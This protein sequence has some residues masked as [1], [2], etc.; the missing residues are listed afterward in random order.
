MDRKETGETPNQLLA[1]ILNTLDGI[2]KI[3]DVVSIFT[4]NKIKMFDDA[5]LRPGRI[6]KVITY[7]L[8]TKDDMLNFFK[9]Y[10]PEEETHFNDML[11][12]IDTISGDV[13]FATLKGICD[14]INIW[15]FNE[16]DITFEIIEEIIKDKIRR[17]DS[18]GDKDKFIL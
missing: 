8:P 13:P 4:T 17:K 6:D 7:R 16:D 2:D 14:E 15:K 18:V 12:F 9:A 11:H 1:K 5:F 10:I 3:E